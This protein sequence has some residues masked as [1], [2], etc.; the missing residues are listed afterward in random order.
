MSKFPILVPVKRPT[1]VTECAA[2]F[3]AA[4]GYLLAAGMVML[5]VPGLLPL[6]VGAPLL[7][8]MEIAGPYLFLL[9][10]AL[11]ALIGGGLL[12][13][14]NWARLMAI[15]VATIG[16][17]ALAPGVFRDVL[18]LQFGDLLWSGLGI[19]SRALVVWYLY[20][21]RVTTG[22]TEKLTSR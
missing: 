18:T 7:Q 11:G 13:A 16:L 3:L 8:G 14:K 6:R 21:W 4:S 9:M 12:C 10:A 19:A 2:L 15:V 1:G 20:H 5:A 22:E 17:A